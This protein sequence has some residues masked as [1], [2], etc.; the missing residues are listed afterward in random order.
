[1]VMGVM[2]KDAKNA[3]ISYSSN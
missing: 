2:P 3:D 1:M